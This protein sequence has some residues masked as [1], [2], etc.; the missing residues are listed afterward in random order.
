MKFKLA[1]LVVCVLIFIQGCAP[2]NVTE[3]E[4]E[5]I[6]IWENTFA[7]ADFVDIINTGSLVPYRQ[8]ME[9]L[10]NPESSIHTNIVLAE[11]F[12]LND[13]SRMV[14]QFNGGFLTDLSIVDSNNREF[15]L[16]FAGFVNCRICGQLAPNFEA[17]IGGNVYTIEDFANVEILMSYARVM[18]LMGRTQEEF[19]V[20]GDTLD[21]VFELNNGALMALMFS[22][23]G[24]LLAM[25]IIYPGGRVFTLQPGLL[26]EM[27]FGERFDRRQLFASQVETFLGIALCSFCQ[28]P[29]PEL[30][31]FGN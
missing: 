29:L 19:L 15:G 10:G 26:F 27:N 17:E 25:H 14:L 16:H 28:Q 7:I 5:E 23:Q 18:E 1:I 9:L 22:R 12:R 3:A 24:L 30:P 13:G 31:E 20:S 21:K 8:V 2:I 11:I 6:E 4:V